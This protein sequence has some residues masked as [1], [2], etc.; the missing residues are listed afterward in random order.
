MAD[1]PV[2]NGQGFDPWLPFRL[3]ALAVFSESERKIY[4]DFYARLSEWLSLVIDAIFGATPKGVPPVHIDPY[5][6]YATVPAWNK[7]MREFAD[8]T[9]RE[10][11]NEPYE[12]LIDD[13]TFE[14]D[15]RP[16]VLSYL[17]EV[18]N[19]MKDTPDE[20]FDLIATEVARG[21]EEGDSIP[22]IAE[23]IDELLSVT[24]TPRWKNR[25]V[26]VARTETIGA[27]NAG[28]NDAFGVVAEEL[29]LDGLGGGFDKVWIAT[30]DD[31]TRPTHQAAHG[32]RVPLSGRFQV[33]LASLSQPGDESGPANETIQCRCT[34]IMVESDEDLG[35]AERSFSNEDA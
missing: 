30:H 20:V 27:L 32:Q 26:V 18:D 8:T 34:T 29:S 13:D 15:T 4:T 23:S 28:R 7:S 31:R 24:D 9:I 17:D 1:E 14:F 2:W 6:V 3:R 5:S 10:V 19:R 16:F 25:A 11:L 22:E 12:E 33:G 21:A 35:L